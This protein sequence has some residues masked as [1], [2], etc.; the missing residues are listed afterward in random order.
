M[1]FEI[2]E[3]VSHMSQDKRLNIM[4]MSESWVSHVTHMTESRHTYEWVTSHMWMSHEWATSH[5]WMNQ[6]TPRNIMRMSQSWV[7]HVTHKNES[8][9]TYERVVSHMRCVMP[10]THMCMCDTHTLVSC[11]K[12]EYHART[13][14]EAGFRP[15]VQLLFDC[16]PFSRAQPHIW[17][18]T[19]KVNFS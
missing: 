18:S 13:F 6:S 2:Y 7:S 3:C 11:Y 9:H 16:V 17:M 8:R 1:K 4:R 12:H 15:R 5:I 10:H 14:S 19:R